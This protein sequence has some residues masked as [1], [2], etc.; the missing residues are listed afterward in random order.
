VH[1]GN[2]VPVV[3]AVHRANP[4]VYAAAEWSTAV[5]MG[6]VPVAAGFEYDAPQAV[7]HQLGGGIMEINGLIARID[8]LRKSEAVALSVLKQDGSTV[9]DYLKCAG[10]MNNSHRDAWPALRDE[11]RRLQVD[12]DDAWY[13]VNSRMHDLSRMMK[14]LDSQQAAIEKAREALSYLPYE[15]ALRLRERIRE[16]L[17][18]LGAPAS[19]AGDAESQVCFVCHGKGEHAPF[20]ALPAGVEPPKMP[21]TVRCKNCGGTGYIAAPKGGE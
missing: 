2:I 15:S 10:E 1:S 4:P 14:Q 16:G 12:N 11:L 7:I 8:A 17:T 5:V 21:A 9:D 13:F 18:S 19:A 20:M 6:C 3:I